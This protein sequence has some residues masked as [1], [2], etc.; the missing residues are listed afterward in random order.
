MRYTC[1]TQPPSSP[2]QK[3]LHHLR[4]RLGQMEGSSMNNVSVAPKANALLKKADECFDLA[5]VQHSAADK[6]HDNAARQLDLAEKQQLMG[7]SQHQ[8]ADEIEI[9]SQTLKDMGDML[10]AQAES[11]KAQ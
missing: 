10:K 1:T 6:Q 8:L 5:K 7:Q 2:F 11:K 3:Q 4:I 9:N